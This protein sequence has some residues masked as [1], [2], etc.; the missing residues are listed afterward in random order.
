MGLDDVMID[1]E[2]QSKSAMIASS[3]IQFEEGLDNVIM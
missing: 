2:S 3:G 1:E